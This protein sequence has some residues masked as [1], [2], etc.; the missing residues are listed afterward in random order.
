[1]IVLFIFANNS[2]S[3]EKKGSIKGKVVFEE[4]NSPIEFANI[5]IFREGDSSNVT[6]TLTDRNGEF[7]LKNIQPGIYEARISFIGYSTEI[8]KNIKISGSKTDFE[9]GE[10]KL[11]ERKEITSEI[12]VEDEAPIMTTE[13]I[14][15]AH[16]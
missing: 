16:V 3:Q 12:V 13:E 7:H 5:Q 14:G 4:G 15:R 8:V 6:G 10:I 9:T 11:K 1:M 2:Y